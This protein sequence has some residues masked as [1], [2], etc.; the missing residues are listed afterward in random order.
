MK[1]VQVCV[2]VF[3]IAAVAACGGSS[4]GGGGGGGDIDAGPG[5]T[6]AGTEVYHPPFE[7]CAGASDMPPLEDPVCL[8]DPAAP[9]ESPPQSII[10]HEITT[11]EGTPA[12]HI[13][14]TLNPDFADNTYGTTAVGWDHHNF[15]DLVGSDHV[16]MIA[17][18][19][20]DEVVFD[21]DIDYITADASAPCGNRSLGVT[22][23]EG[24]VRIGDPGAVLFATTSIDRNLNERGYCL[25]TDSPATDE[26]CTVNP[27]YPD[28]DFRVVYE[29]WLALS[30]F[31][32]DGF[33][34]AFMTEVH[35]S[36]SKADTN[37]I[38][39]VPGE[40][41]CIEIDE[42]DCSDGPPGMCVDD[43]DCGD[44]QFCHDGNCLYIVE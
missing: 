28:W 3:G 1:Q 34:S 42:G 38:V 25:T 11:Y 26:N 15:K 44:G 43:D 23:G 6:D 21:L 24:E 20:T 37:T 35:A 10:E 17:L 39:V 19:S 31:E 30:A 13:S 36:P 33:G 40:C 9:P 22:G 2:T 5:D 16:T 27:D 32:P 18:S 7:E 29:I 8:V 12:V 14:I 4:S 41:P